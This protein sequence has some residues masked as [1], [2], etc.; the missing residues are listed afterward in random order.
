MNPP[1][2][3]SLRWIDELDGSRCL[4]PQVSNP[5]QRGLGWLGIVLSV[6][7][8]AWPFAITA[9]FYG[10]RSDLKPEQEITGVD[11]LP[12][13]FFGSILFPVA[14][15]LCLKSCLSLFGSSELLIDST[16]LSVIRRWGILRRRRRCP[17]STI[18]G[19]RVEKPEDELPTSEANAVAGFSLFANRSSLVARY[20]G[21][22]KLYIV[23]AFP[24][25][26]VE[27]LGDSLPSQVQRIAIRSGIH[28]QGS[29]INKD[30]I[31]ELP[32]ENLDRI[33][34]KPSGDTASQTLSSPPLGSSLVLHKTS[35]GLIIESPKLGYLGSTTR[36]G[37][38]T[39]YA[40]TAIQILLSGGL[41][42]ALL[43]GKVN[44]SPSAGWVIF[45][46]FTAFWIIGVFYLF[47]AAS[48]QGKVTLDDRELS[49]SEKSLYGLKASNWQRREIDSIELGV[50][51]YR[52]DDGVTW[53]Y[54]VKVSPQELEQRAWFS[55]LSKQEVEW[56]VECL[57]I[58]APEIKYSESSDGR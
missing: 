45:V 11:L 52:S 35:G 49:F 39:F 25:A 53:D 30:P 2:N 51:E 42:P 38:L 13:A 17:L 33:Q 46:V 47:Y 3:E 36:V 8:A 7:F 10:V 5:V 37:R 16:H 31:S 55:H 44:G 43:A 40:F 4:L 18:D 15:V 9:F 32:V 6:M 21:G 57:K 14:I 29:S 24:N 50:K 20:S 27:E 23:R 28:R 56:M 19:F 58:S 48:L 26:L 1:M 12:L 41:V 22:R 54:F 34:L